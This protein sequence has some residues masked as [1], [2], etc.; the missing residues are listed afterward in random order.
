[1]DEY[2]D[3]ILT[4]NLNDYLQTGM[5]T[6]KSAWPNTTK[7]SEC[8]D[9][10]RLNSWGVSKVYCTADYMSPHLLYT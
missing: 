7:P 5:D 10:I 3:Q 6:A 2:L 1:M 9:I 8:L 4:L